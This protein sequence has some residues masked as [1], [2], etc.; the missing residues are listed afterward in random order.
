MSD[1]YTYHAS[2]CARA[3]FRVSRGCDSPVLW[4]VL[5]TWDY[6]PQRQPY[7]L[8]VGSAARRIIGVLMFALGEPGVFQVSLDCF[9]HQRKHI[10]IIDE[11]IVYTSTSL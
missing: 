8:S 1:T 10:P 5:C 9:S 4:Y 6:Q 11:H 3:G 2:L 7:V